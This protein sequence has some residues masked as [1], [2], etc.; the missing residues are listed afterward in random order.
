MN[1]I[2]ENN[3]VLRPGPETERFHSQD[4]IRGGLHELPPPLIL[5]DPASAHPL[6][7]CTA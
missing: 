7:T 5:F 2:L 3:P 6:Q 1:E 4:L